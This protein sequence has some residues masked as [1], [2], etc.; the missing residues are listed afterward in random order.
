MNLILTE[1]E[2]KR[3][4]SNIEKIGD[5]WIWKRTVNSTTGR[6]VVS[7]QGKQYQSRKIAFSLWKGPIQP[8]YRILVN[9]KN[10]KCLNPNHLSLSSKKYASGM[11]I[12]KGCK[13]CP[14]CQN[15]LSVDQFKL[16]SSSYDGL[17]SKCI[18]CTN[19]EKKKLWAEDQKFKSKYRDRYYQGKYNITLEEY[20]ALLEAQGYVCAIC[21][22]AEPSGRALSVDH[23]HLTGKLRELLCYRCNTTLG[24][25]ED[26]PQKLIACADYLKKHSVLLV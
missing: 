4:E 6:P 2:I 23:C 1:K 18:F 26:D 25:F 15:M 8:G 20:E 11:E 14:S 21:G 24:K 13:W 17:R 9:C 16:D 3:F 19:E 5:C 22:K 10:I 12:P 7:I